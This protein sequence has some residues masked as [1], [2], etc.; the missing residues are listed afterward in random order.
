M[1]GQTLASMT[2]ARGALPAVEA[3]DLTV[4]VLHALAALDAADPMHRHIAPA[5]ILLD[6]SRPGQVVGIGSAAPMAHEGAADQRTPAAAAPAARVYAAG[7]LLAEMLAGQSLATHGDAPPLAPG[8]QG[9]TPQLP[10]GLGAD[11]DDVLR[12]IVSRAIAPD[13]S[14][15]HTDVEALVQA[16]TDWSATAPDRQG[17]GQPGGSAGALS[18]LMQRMRHNTDFPAMSSSVGRIQGIVSSDTESV[19]SLTNEILKDVALTNKLLRMV[20][21]VH[22]ARGGGA[23]STVSR[24]V[25]LV[26]F[27][28][29]RNMAL[30]LVLLE[31]MQDKAHANDLKDE[32]V[33]CLMAGTVAAQLCAVARDSEEAFVGGMFQ[34]L[35]RLL[36]EFYFPE[37]A[38]TVRRMVHSVQKPV[39]EPLAAAQVLGLDFETLGIGVAKG[40]GLPEG[41]Q[42]CMRKPA[43]RPPATPP[44]D[45]IERLRWISAAANDIADVLLHTETLDVEARLTQ[46]GRHH[47]NVLGFSAQEME[48]NILTGRRQ[49]LELTAA[50]QLQVRPGSGAARLLQLPGDMQ[51]DGALRDPLVLHAVPV[52]DMGPADAV[53]RDDPQF[54]TRTL[55]AGIADVTHAVAEGVG[56][57]DVLRMVLETMLRAMP[58]ERI[59]FCMLDPKTNA[60]TGRFGLGSGVAA[61]VREFQVSLKPTQP[62]LFATVCNRGV[63]TLIS[64]ATEARVA[65]NLPRWYRKSVN[66]TTFLLLPLHLKG[67]PFGLIYADMGA[68]GGVKLDDRELSLLRTLRDQAVTAFRHAA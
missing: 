8:P 45:P 38:R 17:V 59:I 19:S 27:N 16:L 26:G 12:A 53:E 48:A 35:G 25:S 46:C 23:I 56:L 63:D 60:L 4:Q 66:A 34:N 47:A 18:S 11:V 61:V 24:A 39:S 22:L 58:F 6:E 67:K 44:A 36:A 50:M 43:G 42:R 64:D 20:N 31:H 2:A 7:M 65:G 41:I 13:A 1:P 28:G 29:I 51:P 5:R 54:V 52:G 68:Q 55:T 62:D 30:G 57:S 33:R 37:E 9:R 49:L 32:F 14:E 40:W 3:V 21:S 15:R 10:A